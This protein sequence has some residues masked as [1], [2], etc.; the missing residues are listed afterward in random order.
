MDETKQMDLSYRLFILAVILIAALSVSYLAKAVLDYRSLPGNSPREISVS[1]EGKVFVVPDV[2]TISFG[3]N[4]EGSESMD[5]A[6]IVNQNT[7]KMNKI[8][9]DIKA[10]GIN[11]KDIQTTN[12]S[13]TPKYNWTRDA[14]NIFIGYTINQQIEVKIKDFSKIGAT[15]TAGTQGGATVVG[16]LQFTNEDPEKAK[17]E[18]RVKAIEQARAKALAMAGAAGLKLGKLVGISEGYNSYGGMMYEKAAAPSGLGG[19]VTP[20]DIQ[21]GQNEV[22]VN[23][24]ITYRVK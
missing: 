20:P 21:P 8:I 17:S 18:A 14:G 19:A 15:L 9:N 4:N 3:V 13:L 5:I 23:V 7:Q 1:G 11:E 10:L 12:Y 24:T 6:S 2:A 16:N 22:T